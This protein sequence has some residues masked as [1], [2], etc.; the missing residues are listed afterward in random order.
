MHLVGFI[1]PRITM[2]RTTKNGGTS[3]KTV[4][5]F[6]FIEICVIDHWSSSVCDYISLDH[7]VW[8]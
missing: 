8:H 2:H 5:N 3:C 7:E 6:L 1:Q 4:S